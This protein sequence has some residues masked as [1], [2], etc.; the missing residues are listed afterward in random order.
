MM[1]GI[2]VMNSVVAWFVLGLIPAVG[3]LMYQVRRRLVYI[4]QPGEAMTDMSTSL[5]IVALLLT[6]V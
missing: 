2:V 5:L 1:I 4:G 6:V 3:Y